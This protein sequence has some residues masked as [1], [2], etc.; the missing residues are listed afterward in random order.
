MPD[1]Q[2]S[3]APSTAFST[4]VITAFKQGQQHDENCGPI[5]VVKASIATFGP[6][7]KAND[8]PE[9]VFI[10]DTVANGVHSITLRDGTSLELSL[11]ELAEAKAAC[12]FIKPTDDGGNELPGDD[13]IQNRAEYIYAVLAKS[14]SLKGSAHPSQFPCTF[15]D[16]L[17]ELTHRGLDADDVAPLL[18]LGTRT[19]VANSEV[20]YLYG[21]YYH[22]TFATGDKYDEYGTLEGTSQFEKNHHGWFHNNQSWSLVLTVN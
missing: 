18:G 13:A 1:P 7:N 14:T 22:A 10:V 20:A 9:G 6:E 15:S 8:E 16:A 5:S 4:R 21:N 11:A 17:D 2:N 12:G 3:F 19:V